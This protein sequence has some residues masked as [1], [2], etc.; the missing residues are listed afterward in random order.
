MNNAEIERIQRNTVSAEQSLIGAILVENGLMNEIKVTSDNFFLSECGMIFQAIEA[1]HAERKPFDLITLSDW[2][3]SKRNV[4]YFTQLSEYAYNTPSAANGKT[5]AEK[6][7]EY[8]RSRE[9]CRIASDLQG[10]RLSND[11]DMIDKA[12]SQLMSLNVSTKNYNHSASEVIDAALGKVQEACESE[13][14]CTGLRT[15]ITEFDDVTGGLNN[16][17]LIIVGARPAMGKTAFML[18]IATRHPDVRAGICSGEQ[19]YEQMGMRML[20]IHG[21]INGA[22]MRTGDLVDEELTKLTGASAKLYHSDFWV[23]DT[24]NMC[25]TDIERR[26]RQ[27]AHENGVNAIFV[28]YLQKIRH[29]D[30]RMSKVDQIADIAIRLKSLAKE[31]NIPVVALAQVN[32]AV[33]SRPDKRPAMSDIKDCGVIEQEADSIIT[34]Y[35]D[36]VYNEGSPDAGVAELIFCKNRHGPTGVKRVSWIG[37][38]M[39][40]NDFSS[41]KYY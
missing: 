4:D 35:R 20:S 34:L 9:A 33:E 21:S 5:Y 16:T 31:L 14:G 18:N 30:S 27:W 15:G 13:T 26:G 11:Q 7:K 10:I 41:N 37:K 6:V 12:I 32:R 22:R 29:P 23:D 28:D 40:F 1:L 8:W 2:L 39:Q 3:S 19:G 17:D 24:P 38:Y 36:E 25:I